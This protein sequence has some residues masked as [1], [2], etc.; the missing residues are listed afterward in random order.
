MNQNGK[1]QIIDNTLQNQ[2]QRINQIEHKMTDYNTMKQDLAKLQN[3]V[4]DIGKE[5]NGENTKM[6]DFDRSIEHYSALCDDITTENTNRVEIVAEMR[7]QIDKLQQN[8]DTLCK[9]SEVMKT[10]KLIFNVAV[11]EI[12]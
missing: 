10:E 1:W 5:V 7:E 4:Y 12:T 8:Q 2:N 3:T 6:E 11:C 9:T